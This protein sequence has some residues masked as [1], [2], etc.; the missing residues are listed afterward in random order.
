MA[1]SPGTNTLPV[2]GEGSRTQY[3]AIIGGILNVVAIIVDAFL[4]WDIPADV[5]VAAN[6]VLGTLLTIFLGDK[7]ARTEAAAK[8][9]TATVSE[10][11]KK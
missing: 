11:I 2:P 6:T 10:E 4:G 7:M 3:T 1:S 8:E 5:W 9:T